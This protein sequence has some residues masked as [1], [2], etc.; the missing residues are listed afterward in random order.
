MQE[1]I[2]L[3]AKFLKFFAPNIDGKRADNCS[4]LPTATAKASALLIVFSAHPEGQNS[5]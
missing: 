2:E 4:G 5:R 3:R 1:L